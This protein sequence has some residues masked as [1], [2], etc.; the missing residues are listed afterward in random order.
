MDFCISDLV[1]KL[2][3]T[4]TDLLRRIFH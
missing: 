1:A 2:L 3:Q 4:A